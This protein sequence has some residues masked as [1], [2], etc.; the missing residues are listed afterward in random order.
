MAPLLL[1]HLTNHK[2]NPA[3]FM[4][5][6]W[7]VTLA[8]IISIPCLTKA[9]GENTKIDAH[10]ATLVSLKYFSHD[11]LQIILDKIEEA[12]KESNINIIPNEHFEKAEKP[13]LTI[14]IKLADSLMISIKSYGYNGSYTYESDY[15]QKTHKYNGLGDVL[16][17]IKSYIKETIMK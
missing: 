6:F 15:P 16:A 11:S 3:W 5:K 12:I 1:N 17:L 10:I 8:L 9:Q 7:V 4:K 2:T 14:E 13:N